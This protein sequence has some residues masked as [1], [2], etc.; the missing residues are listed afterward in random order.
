[1]E[2]RLMTGLEPGRTLLLEGLRVNVTTAN[3][4]QAQYLII[5]AEAMTG[6]LQVDNA[7]DNYKAVVLPIQC[8]GESSFA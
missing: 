3:C 7:E 4:L 6:F 2:Q 1:M 8:Q 5:F